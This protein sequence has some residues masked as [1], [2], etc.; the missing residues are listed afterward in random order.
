MELTPE[1]HMAAMISEQTRIND[2]E[3]RR[4]ERDAKKSGKL[5]SVMTPVEP[6]IINKKKAAES[7]PLVNPPMNAKPN[8]QMMP[9]IVDEEVSSHYV[10]AQPMV[11]T[12]QV[13]GTVILE[14]YYTVDDLKKY[15]YLIE[16]HA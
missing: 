12:V 6:T 5:P 10:G 9:M 11:R 16:K 15:I 8:P 1:Q 3:R 7:E 4:V 13:R 14:G 2:E